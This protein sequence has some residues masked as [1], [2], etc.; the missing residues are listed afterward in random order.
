M[1]PGPAFSPFPLHLRVFF[2]KACGNAKAY[3]KRLHSQMQ[4]HIRHVTSQTFAHNSFSNPFIPANRF[5]PTHR[6]E[7]PTGAKQS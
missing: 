3:S 7:Y 4:K 2:D 1:C 6:P 5:L